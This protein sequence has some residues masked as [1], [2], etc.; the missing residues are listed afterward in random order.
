MTWVISGR[1]E[2]PTWVVSARNGASIFFAAY[3]KVL[4]QWF[5]VYPGGEERIDEPQMILVEEDY[6]RDH[7]NN[8]FIEKPKI[9]PCRKK[10]AQL[11]LSLR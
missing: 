10:Q 2:P 8:N 4:R 3:S 7:P 5:F 9:A 11:Y 1:V 6:V